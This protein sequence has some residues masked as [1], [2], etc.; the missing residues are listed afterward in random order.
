[1]AEP[2]PQRM[3]LAEFLSW[4]S[5]GDTHWELY[6]G[7]PVAMASP[8]GPHQTMLITFGRKLSE[9][10]DGRPE[11]RVRGQA[12]IVPPWRSDNFYEADL[13]VSCSPVERDAGIKDPILI[14]E[15][16]SPSTERKDRKLKLADYR[17]FDSVQEIV[18]IDPEDHYCE[19]HRRLDDERWLVDLL[20]D[21]VSTVKL[22]SVGCEVALGELYGGLPILRDGAPRR[23]RRRR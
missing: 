12:G 21:P 13:A 19:I 14:V 4:D 18:L 1:M 6:D 20:L 3:S 15:I 5:P 9:A 7:V 8:G 22:N 16:L 11:C 17:E 10:L 23:P 2:L